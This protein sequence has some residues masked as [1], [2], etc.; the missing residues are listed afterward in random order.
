MA[1]T[2]LYQGSPS[3][4]DSGAIVGTTGVIR[5]GSVSTS[6]PDASPATHNSASVS[7]RSSVG[8]SKKG[9]GGGHSDQKAGR[10]SGAVLVIQTPMHL[11]SAL[12]EYPSSPPAE[13]I[14]K[15]GNS[16]QRHD[17]GL[18]DGAVGIGGKGLL[19]SRFFSLP[20]L[21][22]DSR[23]TSV[24]LELD[25]QQHMLHRYSVRVAKPI[26]ANGDSGNKAASYYSESRS[27]GLLSEEDSESASSE[28][29][30]DG[31]DI[32]SRVSYNIGADS[33]DETLELPPGQLI[34]VPL[35]LYVVDTQ[36]GGSSTSEND[37]EIH[38]TCRKQAGGRAAG[39][40]TLSIIPAR[41]ASSKIPLTFPCKRLNE[42]LSFSFQT[43]QGGVSSAVVIAPLLPLPGE[44]YRRGQD[45]RSEDKSSN[46]DNSLHLSS[47]ANS[48]KPEVVS[49]RGKG[50]AARGSSSASRGDR[51]PRGTE[52][53]KR[54]EALRS[55]D[56]THY[57]SSTAARLL[58]E[59]EDSDDTGSPAAYNLLDRDTVGKENLVSTA[60]PVNPSPMELFPDSDL[61]VPKS[62][63]YVHRE[64]KMDGQPLL[65][66]EEHI[67]L[68]YTGNDK[69]AYLV[70]GP[71][72]YFTPEDVSI[73]PVLVTL[74]GQVS[75]AME[76]AESYRVIA[77]SGVW[78]R[79]KATDNLA[80]RLGVEGFWL[81][82]PQL[83]DC[84][85]LLSVDTAVIEDAV[86]GLDKLTRRLHRLPPVWTST[87]RL[88]MG[89]GVGAHAA[90]LAA[91]HRPGSV[92][93]LAPLSLSFIRK[94]NLADVGSYD[95]FFR[96]DAPYMSPALSALLSRAAV[97]Q[98]VDR[99]VG[100]GFAFNIHVRVGSKD[101]ISHPWV[102]KRIY[103]QF[104][105]ALLTRAGVLDMDPTAHSNKDASSRLA[106]KFNSACDSQLVLDI[107]RGHGHWWNDSASSGDGGITND[108]T[109]R[110]FYAKCR[111][112]SIADVISSAE[113]R[114]R[115]EAVTG[116]PDAASAE[117][118]TINTSQIRQEARLDDGHRHCS[119]ASYSII[120][121][122]PSES[123]C[124]CGVC[125]TQQARSLERSDVLV[126]TEIL[127][128][129]QLIM[130]AIREV[131]LQ[132]K[133]KSTGD[134]FED[135]ELNEKEMVYFDMAAEASDLSADEADRNWVAIR[136]GKRKGTPSAFE[137]SR[138]DE[139]TAVSMKRSVR[140][141]IL[142][143]PEMDGLFTLPT[144]VSYGNLCIIRTNNVRRMRLMNVLHQSCRGNSSFSSI[145]TGG[146]ASLSPT[147]VIVDGRIVRPP[148]VGTSAFTAAIFE[149]NYPVVDLCWN[150]KRPSLFDWRDSTVYICSHPMNPLTEKAVLASGS[151]RSLL[152]RPIVIIFG[153]P[154]NLDLRQV[155][156][157]MAVRIAS[158]IAAS[159]GIYV[160]LFSDFEYRDRVNGDVET[161]IMSGSENL[162]FIGGPESNKIMRE[163]VDMTLLGSST[164][165]AFHLPVS[166][167]KQQ[168]G[169]SVGPHRFDASDHGI[170]FLF[171]AATALKASSPW[172]A[173]FFVDEN[174]EHFTEVR[175]SLAMCVA[176]N[177]LSGYHHTT[178]LLQSS[179]G[180]F[181]LAIP[182]FVVTSARVWSHGMAGGSP[183][184][185][186]WNATW[187]F[188]QSQS[189]YGADADAFRD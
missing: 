24:R 115:Q 106:D 121:Y 91:L 16:P 184:L 65:Q 100:N 107:V 148:R 51:A 163:V 140:Q 20:I 99:L 175:P 14:R 75:T 12:L 38:L 15:P 92:A 116:T 62:Q 96:T 180:P 56:S 182:D 60:L 114:R 33:S 77:K 84:D 172:P 29:W 32:G 87:G 49:I 61:A 164:S 80:P 155:L 30:Q 161:S 78:G 126:K 160:H 181:Q 104:H 90:V 79:G 188:D 177:S 45:V 110:E 35:E 17:W 22:T 2:S 130:R 119:E 3:A 74:H 10:G 159:T 151:M 48:G 72:S 58:A 108:A 135:F 123:E 73:F 37:D 173:Q 112:R 42:T 71:D 27:L 101:T 133:A 13:V 137:S 5:E 82:V 166:F 156:R 141:K 88:L 131:N 59:R 18:A 136:A 52:A 46:V 189:Y 178:R 124:Y 132:S 94:E 86:S 169:F 138:N 146:N 44:Q 170:L 26:P 111:T 81:L 4:G 93:C 118:V 39:S 183:L 122:S 154:S 66:G 102:S 176:A 174:V 57:S 31:R 41:G 153:T 109:I 103:R 128:R 162:I 70:S 143:H 69:I 125:V 145:R 54:F 129:R 11:S 89:H 171:P 36:T 187:G 68:Q 47:K 157:D 19:L 64:K 95:A 67:Y 85:M 149:V 105:E 168:Q 8:N 152:S 1:Y 147:L 55:A 165:T 50:V 167:L 83:G 7:G 179:D 186:F 120:L 185:G 97:S 6:K 76:L 53:G 21:N 9:A 98:Q 23:S 139:D 158:T 25:G 34:M 43:T 144:H 40:L 134:Y 142:Q 150:S 113:F 127:P 28:G 117:G 63:F